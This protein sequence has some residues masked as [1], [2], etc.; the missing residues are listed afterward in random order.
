MKKTISSMLAA[1]TLITAIPLSPAKAAENPDLQALASSLGADTDY[2]NIPNFVHDNK[3]RRLLNSSF[4]SYYY[5]CNN[6]DALIYPDMYFA[7]SL[8]G[9]VCFGISVLEIL[10]HNGVISPSDILDGAE[11]MNEIQY[12]EP[13]DHFVT[14]YQAMQN[15]YELKYGIYDMA[16]NCTAK[17]QAEILINTAR[18]CMDKKKYFYI[19]CYTD[20][21]NHAIVGIGISDGNWEYNGK[22]YDKCILTLDSNNKDENGNAVPFKESTCIYINSNEGRIYIPEYDNSSDNDLII[23]VIDDDSLINYKGLI[24]PSEKYETDLSSS[25]IVTL[26]HE[27]AVKYDITA[28]DEKDDIIKMSETGNKIE[29]FINSYSYLLKGKKFHIDTELDKNSKRLNTQHVRVVNLAGGFE[30]GS[31]DE[32]GIFDIINNEKFKITSKY[33]N[34]TDYEM[35]LRFNEGYY[36]FTPHY[37]YIFFGHTDSFISAEVVESGILLSSDSV[38]E[39]TFDTKD[40]LFDEQM[41]HQDMR[42]NKISSAITAD[43]S[44]LISFDENNS[45]AFYIDPDE[46]GVYD[47]PVEKG[48]VNSDGVIDGRD[49][50]AVLESYAISSVES[51]ETSYIN[52]DFADFD[53]N[54]V[55]DG[56]DASEILVQYA[57]SSVK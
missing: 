40:V 11:K 42:G 10:A 48:D 15:R 47:I 23:S 6:Y 51:N 36:P 7:E 52:F 16:L 50:S 45:I 21:S 9:G 4:L 5:A 12:S 41:N 43:N 2:L 8:A 20:E 29:E 3:E 24:N 35:Y 26:W 30:L 17:E 38:I 32:T 44:I 27:A 25:N 37:N 56:R 46:D 28:Y 33:N 1:L 22:N 39:M 54:G 13:V 49:A 31:K 55:I 34:D 53:G 14:G 19:G 18:E 57:E